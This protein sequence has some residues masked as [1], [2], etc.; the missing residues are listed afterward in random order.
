MIDDYADVLVSFKLA[1]YK[2]YLETIDD[3]EFD[4]ECRE[5]LG[6]GGSNAVG[7]MLDKMLDWYANELYDDP[8]FTPFDVDRIYFKEV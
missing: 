5:R 6:E 3:E 1:V 7:Q 2:R 4:Y 8:S